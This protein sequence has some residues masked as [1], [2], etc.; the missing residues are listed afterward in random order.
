MFDE[1]LVVFAGAAKSSRQSKGSLEKVV[2]RVVLPDVNLKS[3]TLKSSSKP[4]QIEKANLKFS[5]RISFNSCLNARKSHVSVW[6]VK[7]VYLSACDVVP[8]PNPRLLGEEVDEQK[9]SIDTESLPVFDFLIV[10]GL[11]AGDSS[12]LISWT[13]LVTCCVL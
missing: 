12:K 8:E 7:F 11:G 5:S 10:G 1:M 6:S 2:E 13:L 4:L 3:D 9:L